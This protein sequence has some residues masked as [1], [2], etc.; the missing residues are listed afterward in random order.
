MQE[1]FLIWP[2]LDP[3]L[4]KW[5]SQIKSFDTLMNGC[6]MFGLWKQNL[7][8]SYF[9]IQQFSKNTSAVIVP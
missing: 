5:K 1:Y 4:H 9:D 3:E 2:T 6:I 7:K 8:S